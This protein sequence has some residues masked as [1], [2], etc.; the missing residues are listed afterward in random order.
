MREMFKIL[1]KKHVSVTF[2]SDINKFN[3]STKNLGI[4]VYF[5]GFE[6]IISNQVYIKKKKIPGIFLI[7]QTFLQ[8][9]FRFLPDES[10]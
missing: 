3:N 7:Q 2:Q 5:N 9:I 8:N 6:N 10:D 4:V 1:N